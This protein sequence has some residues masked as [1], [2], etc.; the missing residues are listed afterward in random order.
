MDLAAIDPNNLSSLSD[1]EFTA[2]ANQLL[3]RQALDRQ[4]NALRY[5]QPVSDKAR[6]IH[7]CTKKTIGVGE[8]MAQFK[9][10]SCL[11]EMVIR[12]TGQVPLSLRDVYPMQTAGTL[13]CRLVCESLTTTLALSSSPNCSGGDGAA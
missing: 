2:I 12:A 3:Q 11:V 9:T 4:Q 5:Y 8:A 13:A 1:E 7:T 10:E 6:Q